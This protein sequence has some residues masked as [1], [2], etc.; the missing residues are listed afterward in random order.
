MIAPYLRGY[1]TT[2]FLSSDTPRNGQQ[3]ALAADTIALMD[4][5]AIDKA[6]IAGFDWGARTANIVA[7]L[8]PERCTGTVSVSGYLIG[9]REA[10][11]S[12]LPPQAEPDTGSG[13]HMNAEPYKQRLLGMEQTLS[14]RIGREADQGRGEF[15]DSAHDAGDASVADQVSSEQFTEAEHDANVLQQ[16]RDAL[17]RIADGTFGTCIVDRGPI[18]EQRLEALPW[19]PYC[20]KHA[21]RLEAATSARTPTL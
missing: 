8:W 21:T 20:L 1:G 14:A 15:I 12:P 16:V 10:N 6:T 11:R 17:G 18:E 4:A 3:A 19:T 7:A 9:S 13:E 2:R 5:L